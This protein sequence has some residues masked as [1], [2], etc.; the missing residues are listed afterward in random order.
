MLEWHEYVEQ[1]LQSESE[2]DG[3]SL[4][5]D[6]YSNDTGVPPIIKSS[7]LML[8]KMIQ[9]Q[10]KY[11]IIVFP[12]RVQSIFIFT[13]MKL[14]HNIAQGKI[15]K[16]YDPSDF[17]PG[18]KLKLGN[19]VVEFLGLEERDG[20]PC[21]KIGLADLISSA[22]IEFFPL[23]QR[24]STQRRL[25]KYT[26]FV[27]ARKKAESQITYLSPNEQQ[28]A[29]LSD[30]KTHMNSSIF[31]M[32]SII[33]AKE[34]VAG[35][36]ICGKKISDLLLIGQADYAGAIRNVGA[37][38]LAG[39]P[40]IVL[41]PD[42]YAIVA[43]SDNGHPVQSVII[44]ASDSNR[45]LTQMDALDDL[46]RLGVPVI[47]VTDVVNSFDLQ[48]F[49][50]RGFNI[51]RWDEL[52]ITPKLY[53]A[54]PLPLDR[55]IRN[56]AARK[57]EYL[58][59]DGNEISD[60]IR[61]LASHRSE[62]KEQSVHMIRIFDNLN[63]LAFAALRETVSFGNSEIER[64]NLLL[65]NSLQTLISEKPFLALSTY[66]GY[67]EV[68]NCLKK[69]YSGDYQLLKQ[70]ALADHLQIENHKDICIV[71]PERT[72]K[73]HVR[74][75]W[76]GWCQ[77]SGLHTMVHV[78]HPAEYYS[79]S[80]T[81][82]SATV[83]T[84][85]LKRAIMRKILYSF[86]TQHYIVLL[87]DYEHRWK[88]YDTAKWNSALKRSSNKTIIIHSFS[89]DQLNI[90]THR[91]AESNK[92]EPAET[93]AVD[94]LNE[95]ELILRENKFRQYAANGGTKPT[96]A[97][98]EAMPVNYVGGFLAFYR[99]G[100]KIVSATKVI[101]QDAEKID[102]VLPN[103]L[104]VGDFVVV[105]EAD[106][107]LI[108]EMADILLSNSGK[109]GLRELATKW[110]E[111]LEIEQLFSSP[112]EIYQKLVNVGC[113]KGYPTVRSWLTD[114]DVIAPQQKQDLR[115]IAEITENS[116]IIELLDQIFDAAQE[117]KS[118]HVQAGRVLSVQ[119]RSRIV[120]ALEGY[121]DI[122]PFNIWEPIEMILEGIGPVK[123]LKIIDVG[124]PIVVDIAD[125]NRL[126]EE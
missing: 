26:Q 102:T 31:N 67:K 84:G 28:L 80:C 22:P 120:E 13:L 100:H 106:R 98:T 2:F 99:T 91:F 68:I 58:K 72:D 17:R 34:T 94:E 62:S 83:V 86:N 56:C 103:E 27:A 37:G 75:F 60:A 101:I 87:Y 53:D 82:F 109:P 48:P 116:V 63:S 52:S 105:R 36:R 110:K 76:Q 9:H 43:A 3:I 18:E 65:N 19:A 57:V 14:L 1:L 88:N 23:F 12:E 66:E 85:W 29:V 20:K 25:S 69:I 33:R 93:P 59:V 8:D 16:T 41:A 124:S 97:T 46:M 73:E 90:S 40:S 108:K 70:K 45:I 5:F 112:E 50:I 21:L 51:W 119:L 71:V 126:I 24:T 42:M 81:A 113:A 115:Y 92:P 38:Q 95:I 77:R 111:A 74:V 54:T 104:Q 78:L 35:C 39:I 32:T 125:T 10:G 55:K 44:D 6:G 107:D 7:I 11:N 118:A 4:S 47:C 49:E 64:A 15:E 96:E 117:V 123:I 61:L 121:G 79:A 30:Y 122:D 114:E 89:N